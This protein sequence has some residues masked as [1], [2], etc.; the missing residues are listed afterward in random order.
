MYEMLSPIILFSFFWKL[1]VGTFTCPTLGSWVPLFW[2]SGS[3]SSGF[4]SQSGFIHICIAEANVMYIPWD[5]PLVLHIAN[6]LTDSIAGHWPGPYLTQGYYL[7]Q[8]GF[9]L[10]SHDY[11]FYAPTTRLRVPVEIQSLFNYITHDCLIHL[12]YKSETLYVEL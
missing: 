12:F 8:W 6:L 11:E 5:P 4:Q 7:H 10:Q 3:V 2:I 1:F 9:N